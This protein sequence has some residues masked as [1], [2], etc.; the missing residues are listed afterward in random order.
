[1]SGK[2]RKAREETPQSYLPVRKR[3]KNQQKIIRRSNGQPVT[4]T[5]EQLKLFDPKFIA[6]LDRKAINEV[7]QAFRY[8][9]EAG[10]RFPRNIAPNPLFNFVAYLYQWEQLKLW[11]AQ[12][13]PPDQQDFFR[14]RHPIDLEYYE[15]LKRLKI[16]AAIQPENQLLQRLKRFQKLHRRLVTSLQKG[17]LPIQY[18]VAKVAGAFLQRNILPFKKEVRGEALERW[19]AFNH[20]SLRQKT[21]KQKQTRWKRIYRVLGLQPLPPAP[22]S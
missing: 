21:L 9:D 7:L 1:M 19:A 14:T 20:A 4:P 8:K 10:N 2:P 17:S 3:L 12:N 18:F 15:Q 11:V 13:V 22:A 16:I 6:L 5:P